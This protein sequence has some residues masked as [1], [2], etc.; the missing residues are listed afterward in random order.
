M[1]G[2]WYIEARWYGEEVP[3]GLLRFPCFILSRFDSEAV[4]LN[5]A[6]LGGGGLLAV[7]TI[8][9]LLIDPTALAAPAPPGPPPAPGPMTACS[10]RFFRTNSCKCLLTSGLATALCSCRDFCFK[11]SNFNFSW[12]ESWGWPSAW[13]PAPD[14]AVWQPSLAWRWASTYKN[15]SITIVKSCAST[16]STIIHLR[17]IKVSSYSASCV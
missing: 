3:W 14:D 4:F 9:R 8:F 16:S 7:G 2:W 10:L 1:A 11:I 13:P 5:K 17:L 15:V 6:W 12:W